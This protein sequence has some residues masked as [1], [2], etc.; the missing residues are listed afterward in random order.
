MS[1]GKIYKKLS[2]KF[3]AVMNMHFLPVHKQYIKYSSVF[4]AFYDSSMVKYRADKEDD[5]LFYANQEFLHMTGYSA[6]PREIEK[7]CSVPL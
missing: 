6:Y 5:E 3:I 4:L 1:S 2:Q 7:C